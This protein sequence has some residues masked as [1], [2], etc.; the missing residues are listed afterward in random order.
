MGVSE[1]LVRAKQSTYAGVGDDAG[2]NL[3]DG[4]RELTYAELPL[5]YRD[6]YYGWGP[7][8]GEEVVQKD[9]RVVWSM[10]YYGR[11]LSNEITANQIYC[12]LVKALGRV[13]AENPFRGPEEYR[14]GDW[15]YTCAVSG[16]V[17]EFNG[18]EKILYDKREVYRLM[19]H[20]GDVG[21]KPD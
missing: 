6:R 10:N 12:F 3:T 9:G 18:S 7:F 21:W 11:C 15:R 4:A 8:S 1:F 19:F 13:V 20:G 17:H 5:V 2:V 14:E 16:D